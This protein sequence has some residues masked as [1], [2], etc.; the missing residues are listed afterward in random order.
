MRFLI[1][2]SRLP[3]G[4]RQPAAMQGAWLTYRPFDF[5]ERCR[6]HHGE[7]FTLRIPSL[8]RVP[9]FT[10]PQD[11]EQIFELDGRLASGG[12]AQSPLVDFAGDQSLMK[13]DGEI[14]RDH[15]EVLCRA[16]KPSELP[17]G[18]DPLLDRIRE[19]VGTWPV[20][21][22]FDLG[23][24]LNRLALLLVSELALSEAPLDLIQTAANTLEGLRRDVR[25]MG[26]IRK[27]LVP[28][29]RS[30]FQPLR[31]VAEPYLAAKFNGSEGFSAASKSCVFA[32]MAAARLSRGRRL[33][34]TAVR[35]EMMTV[36][37]AMM[38]GFSCG[39][40]HAFYWIL[41]TPGTQARLRDPGDASLA[42][43][44]AGEI[45]RRPFLDATCKEVLRF[46]PDIPFAVRKAE[47]DVDIGRWRLPASTTFGIGIYLTHRRASSFE[48]PDRFRPERF[49]TARPSRFEY[50]P[51]GGG[52][53]GCV[54]GPFYVFV[55]KM[56][57]AAAFERFQLVLCDRRK[58]PVTLM[59]IVSS[60]SQ[61]DLGCREAGVMRH[62]TRRR[63]SPCGR[64]SLA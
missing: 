19:T 33:D 28:R 37:V 60:P 44:T 52:R 6:D 26:L 21:R 30:P 11:I 22:R 38:A 51:F 35:D 59:A 29:N 47:A 8:G 4:P 32:R 7:T 34:V 10:K 18:G 39:L 41:S 43:A 3:P 15:R 12:A 25:P 23:R 9:I 36:L 56:I 57:L 64:I 13:L 46:C 62:G 1:D 50:L 14:H 2:R 49:L 42:R 54:A 16:L 24:A 45:S 31:S 27:A 58:N 61:A 17:E 63:T 40:K 55:Q 20:G 5:L 53:R 48:E